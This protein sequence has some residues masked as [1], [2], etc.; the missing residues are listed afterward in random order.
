[1]STQRALIHP[2]LTTI[3]PV[4]ST[5]LPKRREDRHDEA[6]LLAVEAGVAWRWSAS[7][8]RASDQEPFPRDMVRAVLLQAGDHWQGGVWSLAARVVIY[9]TLRKWAARGTAPARVFSWLVEVEGY[10]QTELAAKLDPELADSLRRVCESLLF[11]QFVARWR[12][13]VAPDAGCQR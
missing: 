8:R 5:R 10:M 11:D 2:D 12:E 1:M 13:V 7:A 9:E 3:R 6:L 4:R